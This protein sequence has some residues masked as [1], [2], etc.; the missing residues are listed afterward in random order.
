MLKIKAAKW[1]GK[2]PRH[3]MFDPEADGV[4][5]VRGGCPHC[6][7]LLTIYQNH[8]R[9]LQLM[10]AFAPFPVEHKEAPEPAPDPQP[11]L[12]ASLL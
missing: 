4:G 3:P 12:F 8:Q 2:C 9:T 5:A 11:D 7:E 10:R 1:F 6:L